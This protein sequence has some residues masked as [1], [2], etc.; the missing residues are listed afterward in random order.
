MVGDWETVELGEVASVRSGYAFKSSDWTD[1]GI[2]VVKI[3]NVKG[4][5]GDVP[6]SVKSD[7]WLEID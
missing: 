2:P 5:R 6:E 7:G 4:G 3:A 1:S